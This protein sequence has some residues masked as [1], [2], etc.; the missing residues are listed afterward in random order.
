M[1]HPNRMRLSKLSLG[2][3]LALAAAPVFAQSTSAGVGG[4][5]VS[6]DGQPVAGAEVTITHI[7]SGTVSRITTDASG[8]YSARGLRV[9]GPYTIT[10]NKA[11]AGSDTEENVFLSLSQNNTVDAKLN[12]D[13]TTLGSVQAVASAGATVFSANKMGAGTS[14]DRDTIESLPSIN[15]NIQDFMRLDPRVAF[16]DRASGVISAGGQNPRFNAISI[17]GVSSSDTFGLESNN[18]TTRRQPVSLEAIEAIDISLSNFDVTIAGAAGANVNAV[19]KSGTN[20][21]HGSLYGT[22]RDGD[23]FGNNPAGKPFAGFDTEK[24]Y[25]VTFGGPLIKDRLF[26]F[27]NY[28]KFKQ[29]APGTDLSTTALGKANAV[30]TPA[31]VARAQSIA[32]GTWGFDAGT[33]ESNGNTDLEEYALK[34]DWNISDNHRASIRYSNLVQSK[35]RVQGMGSSSVSLSSYW[36]QHEK[37]VES[38]VAQ[39]FSDWT[40]NFSTEFKASFRD[41]SAIRVVNATAPSVRIFFGGTEASP[42]GD[43]IYLGTEANSQNNVLNTKTWNYYGA[44]T[45]TLGN[46]DVKFGAEYADNEI[47]NYYGRNSWGTY[48][49]FGLDNFQAG[50]WSN[51]DY[52]KETAPGSIA[53]DYSNTNLGLFVQDSWYVNSNLTLTYGVRAD[54]PDVSRDPAYNAAASAYFGYNN[55]KVF[56]GGFLI[57]PRVGFNYTFDSDRQMQLRGGIGLFQGDAPQ[58]WIGNSFNTTGFNYAAYGYKTYDPTLPFSPDAFNQPVPTGA[59]KGGAQDVNFVGND[60]KLPSIWKANLGFET[61]TGLW[62]TVFSIEALLSKVN[63]GLYYQSLNIGPNPVA[64]QGPMPSFTGPDGRELYYNP[65]KIGKAWA[66]GDARFGRNTAYNNVYLIQNTRK[67]VSQ[68]LTASLSKPWTNDSDWSWNMGYTYTHATEVGPLTSSTASSGWGYQYS[69]DIN[70]D[71]ET[72]ARYQIKDRFSGSLNWKH[73][74]FTGYE[75]RMGLV[76]EGRSGR[77]FS[78]VYVNDANG[79]SRTANDLF[80]VPKGPGDVLFGTLTS[81]GVFTPDAVMEK[82]FFAWLGANKDLAPMGG[83]VATTNGFRADFVNTF[84]LRL[85]QEMP[86]FFK[87]HKSEFWVDVQNIGNMLN[88]KWGNIYDYGFYADARVASLQGIYN[89]KYVYNYRFADE[90][91]IANGDG[92]GFDQGISQWSVQLGFKY[93]F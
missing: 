34:L 84:D 10:I 81:A 28:E 90:P 42:S 13:V 62:G 74:F 14:V 68:Q 73:E 52:S 40:E 78:Y 27:A 23:W 67:G 69:F 83:R 3:L 38:Y 21:F 93:K 39:V 9:G 8:R 71:I 31:D 25:G 19:T 47:Y 80:Y 56:G 51:Y 2:L 72:K 1:S 11:G 41:Y 43:S 7:D 61:E 35:L 89:G 60:F 6:A 33:L 22:Y 55:S 32:N 59:G 57:Q 4:Q 66:S 79:D 44:G 45:L 86:G 91:T 87:G 30:I 15:G 26:F 48:T 46:H 20:Q 17:D 75:T 37:S 49:F 77:P 76:Y 58:V 85:S 50:K 24:T 92:D 70:R 36:Y 29:S 63:N 54:R 12:N 64:G 5:V 82:E 16:V 65:G 88:K 53:V 18:M